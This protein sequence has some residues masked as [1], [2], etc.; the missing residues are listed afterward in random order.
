MTAQGIQAGFQTRF[1]GWWRPQQTRA[2]IKHPIC[3]VGYNFRIIAGLN[4]P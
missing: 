3:E 2:Y 1:T 4:T